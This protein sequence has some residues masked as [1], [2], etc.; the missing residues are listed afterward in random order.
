M[1]AEDFKEWLR[2]G[3]PI[4]EDHEAG[5]VESSR[6]LPGFTAED[7][8]KEGLRD[9]FEK[10]KNPELT[11][12]GSNAAGSN[13]DRIDAAQFALEKLAKSQKPASE[14]SKNEVSSTEM[15]LDAILGDFVDFPP[16]ETVSG[17]HKGTEEE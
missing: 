6:T 13:A 9:A 15:R 8:E 16:T 10:L 7:L 4:D 12:A 5:S 17:A 11:F 2:A 14:A 3:A 1:K